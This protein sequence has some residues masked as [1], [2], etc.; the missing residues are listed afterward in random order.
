MCES[1][2][3]VM[4]VKKEVEVEEVSF[5]YFSCDEIIKKYAI[6]R[7]D[8]NSYAVIE[9]ETKE[10]LKYFK[11]FEKL[12]N[13]NSFLIE[14][15][16]GKKQLMH[17]KGY[18]YRAPSIEWRLEFSEEINE[19][20]KEFKS[21][22]LVET[23]DNIRRIISLKYISRFHEWN[24]FDTHYEDLVVIELLNGKH[25]I[26]I[27]DGL[28]FNDKLEFKAMY[29][30]NINSFVTV[31]LDNN[32]EVLVRL[33]DLKCSEEFDE[34]SYYN[35]TRCNRSG[36]SNY[37]VV[38]YKKDKKLAIMRVSDFKLSDRYDT[39]TCFSSDYALGEKNG[40]EIIFRLKDYKEAKFEDE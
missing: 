33:S 17:F 13:E 22:L 14:L 37:A 2:K 36:S 7:I 29:L 3:F 1:S 35:S 5:D 10:V 31:W 16:N 6:V 21:Y 32:K 11:R 40:K 8:K 23:N 15:E 25:T 12:Q 28:R 9:R 38:Y 27:K 20:L 18:A 4:S 39:I 24:Y 26:L 19:L 30:H 34:F